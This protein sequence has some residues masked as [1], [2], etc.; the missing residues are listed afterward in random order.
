[1]RTNIQTLGILP[2][3]TRAQNSAALNAICVPGAK[4]R[5]WAPG[6]HY[7]FDYDHNHNCDFDLDGD[8]DDAI[9]DLD[10][11]SNGTGLTITGALQAMPAMVSGYKGDSFLPFASDPSLSAGNIFALYDRTDYSWSA[12]RPLYHKGEFCMARGMGP[13]N[14]ARLTSPLYDSYVP[15][16]TD[17]YRLVSPRVSIKNVKF[18]SSSLASPVRIS[19]C[20][21][22]IIENVTG[23]NESYQ[24]IEFDRCYRPQIVNPD[25][26]NKGDGR[27][28]YGLVLTN[29]QHARVWGGSLYARRHGIAIGGD[30]N[31]GAVVGRDNKIIG[32]TISNDPTSLVYSADM[33]GNMEGCSYDGC[34]IYGGAGLAGMDNGY[35]NCTIYNAQGGWCVYAGEVQ[36]GEM[37]LRGNNLITYGDP[38]A[39]SRGIVDFGGNSVAIG[40]HTVRTLSIIAENNSVRADNASASTSFMV[41]ANRGTDV[42]IDVRINGLT[43]YGDMA[44]MG[45][46]LRTRRDSGGV[47]S[48]GFVVDNLSGFPTNTIL[49][50]SQDSAY[51]NV[52]QRLQV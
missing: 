45:A 28:D 32:T 13:S 46:I 6:G 21:R 29:C 27:D 52:R 12:S 11:P 43:A 4:L 38:S 33:H 49:H 39:N 40:T 37:Y 25:L 31:P 51:Q 19:L 18:V 5:L 36:G 35:N 2:T 15:A 50:L 14:A 7:Q 24:V 44:A 41:M 17:V 8:R 3:N 10:G 20:D 34:T 23:Y 1:M 22:P 47:Y 9:F 16:N 26:Y 30:S 42:N 48:R